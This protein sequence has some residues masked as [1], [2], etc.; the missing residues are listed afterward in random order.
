MKTLSRRIGRAGLRIS[1]FS[2]P[3][4]FCSI[5]PTMPALPASIGV[6]LLMFGWCHACFSVPTAAHASNAHVCESYGSKNNSVTLFEARLTP[7]CEPGF[8][9]HDLRVLGLCVRSH[10]AIAPCVYTHTQS[11]SAPVA[12]RGAAPWRRARRILEVAIEPPSYARLVCSLGLL[13]RGVI[14]HAS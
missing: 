9:Y 8:M 14:N 3:S 7:G 1:M 11:R 10:T 13:V 6:L 5:R 12:T 2:I 4:Y